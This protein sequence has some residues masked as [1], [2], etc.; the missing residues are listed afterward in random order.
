MERTEIEP[1][2]AAEPGESTMPVLLGEVDGNGIAVACAAVIVP[3]I[4]A[5]MSTS[6]E[7]IAAILVTGGVLLH[8]SQISPTAPNGLSEP[9]HG[10]RQTA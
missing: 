1:G 5:P 10:L 4:T 2:P 3:N 8:G 6:E 9:H 7:T